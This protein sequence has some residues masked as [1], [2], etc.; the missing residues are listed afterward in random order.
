[1]IV[2]IMRLVLIFLIGVA[3]VAYTI[4]KER[5]KS[6]IIEKESDRADKSIELQVSKPC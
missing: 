1:M 3:V 5:K 2:L 6:E 4:S